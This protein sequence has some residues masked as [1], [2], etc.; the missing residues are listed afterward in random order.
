MSGYALYI[1]NNRLAFDLNYLAEKHF[2]QE[3]DIEIPDGD[4]TLGFEFVV[5]KPDQGVGRLLI[6]GAPA[7]NVAIK[8]YPLFS[9]GKFA[10]GRY[11]LSPVA[12]DMK[13]KNYFRYAGVLDRVEIDMERPTDDMDIM[14]EIEHE[15]NNQ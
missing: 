10:I 5:T 15:H 9:G 3:S 2:H 8:A 1:K 13:A 14:L 7:G 6:D 12:K 11:A 4:I